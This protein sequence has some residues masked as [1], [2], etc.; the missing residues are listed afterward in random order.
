MNDRLDS[1]IRELTYRL[2]YMAPEAPPFP[3]ESM[4][5]L[6]T[7]SRGPR[8]PVLVWAAAALG[9]L[10][11]VGVPVL[12]LRS[13]ETAEPATTVPPASSTSTTAETTTTTVPVGVVA[14]TEFNVYFLSDEVEGPNGDAGLVAVRRSQ[15]HTAPVEDP[16]RAALFDALTSLVVDGPGDSGLYSSIPEGIAVGVGVEDGI[17]TVDLPA[18]FESGGGSAMM[19]SRLAQVVFT[20]TQFPELDAMRF[21]IDGQIVDV[22]TSE[23]IIVDGPQSR[24]NYL[25][26]LQPIL[27]DSPA[28]GAVVESP[29]TIGGVAN[30]F[31]AALAYEI[32]TASG[33]VLADGFT[34]ATCGTGCWGD[35]T[36]EVP[37]TLETETAGFVTVFA[38]SPEDGRRINVVS[39]PVTLTGE[40]GETPETTP[41]AEP[42][43]EIAFLTQVSAT[44]IVAD[45]AE[46]LTGDEANQAAFEDGVIGSVDEGVPNDYYIRNQD[47]QL[48]TL[49]VADGV[50]VVLQTSATGSVSGV[51]VPMD[52]WLALF[53]ADG[54]P[55][56]Y[57]VDEVPSWP[58]PHMGYFGAG[59]KGA[60]YWLTFDADGNVIEIEQQYL[61]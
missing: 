16:V 56:D 44:E 18:A 24:D 42:G 10:V 14:F 8:R 4:T 61:P 39:Y 6:Q 53:K 55:W 29:V 30:V 9:A 2:M 7:P 57:E 25:D 40:G 32:T 33:D 19:F 59:T 31:E 28:I 12:L 20:A 22:I 23:G 21:S 48:R 46:M 34:N 36:V 13:S 41:A 5:T 50:T 54:T 37:Y 47:D 26:L 3:E 35:Y 38:N 15:D 52:E 49:A 45:S 11:L 43:R 17:V 58:E 51:E 60:P 27:V 1:R